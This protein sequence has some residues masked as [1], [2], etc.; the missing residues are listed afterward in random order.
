MPESEII[1]V[2]SLGRQD[3]RV[4]VVCLSLL[5]QF[6]LRAGGV[7]RPIATGSRRLL[8]L[9]ALTDKRMR[10]PMVAG[11]L[12]PEANDGRASA[13]LRSAIARLGHANMDVLCVNATELSLN[14]AVC[15]DL[16]DAEADA[17]RLTSGR[18]P[19]RQA[20][21][22]GESVRRLSLELLPGWYDDWVLIEA[23]AWR[24]LRLHALEALSMRLSS[25]A[26]H[27]EAIL[28]AL[29]AVSTD[30]LRET[31][32]HVLIH[33]YVAEG[34]RCE[35]RR[36]FEKYRDLL[37]SSLGVEPTQRLRALAGAE[38]TPSQHRH[39]TVRR[40]GDDAT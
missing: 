3:D 4:G 20:D 38:P 28:A 17:R 27:A 6:S 10:R 34:N 9:L 19:L 32:R 13:C 15:V 37:F 8:A 12:W 5:G 1:P 2:A 33:A 16:R 11:I 26:C 31:A 21:R 36:E 24:Q 29:A 35:A 40:F 7:E 14:A 18:G 30:P 23:E 39:S 22:C 25:A